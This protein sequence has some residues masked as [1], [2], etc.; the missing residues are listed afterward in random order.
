MV[1]SNI[2]IYF[3]LGFFIGI[4]IGIIG[5]LLY[6]GIAIEGFVNN[7]LPKV[8]IENI[9]LEFNETE[10]VRGLNETIIPQLKKEAGK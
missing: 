2:N 8:Q 10:F 1:K 6:A 3:A 7:I 4:S 5:T 9:N